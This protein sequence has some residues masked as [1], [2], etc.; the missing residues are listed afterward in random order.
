[1]RQPA[2]A[3]SRALTAV[4]VVVATSA[5]MPSGPAASFVPPSRP[6]DFSLADVPWGIS[7]DSVASLVSPRGYNYNRTDKDGDLWFD[8]VLYRSPTRVFAFMA[9]QKLTKFRVL[10]STPDER[11][12]PVYQA[13]RAELIRI[14]GQPRE[15]IEEYEAPYTKGDNK[16]LDAFRDKKAVMRTYWIPSGSR[17]ALVAV[18]VT[19][20]LA[21]VV[22]YEGSAWNKESV[23]RRQAGE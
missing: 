2:R 20:K 11:A 10:I 21:V 22:D 9:Q 4:A 6:A 8:G 23:R 13:A 7:A 3:L 1:M 5:C 16:Q 14:Y 19:D 18:A 15:T 17:T 12:I